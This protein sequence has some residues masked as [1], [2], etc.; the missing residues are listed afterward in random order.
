[1]TNKEI[2]EYIIKCLYDRDDWIKQVTDIEY[3]TRCPYCGDSANE[4]TGHFYIRI[5]PYDNYSI[6]YNCFKCQESGILTNETL[7]MLGIDDVNLKSSVLTMNKTSDKLD[8]KYLLEK[9]E[10]VTFD[11]ELPTPSRG[12]QTTYLEN[13]LGISLTDEDLKNLKVIT[14]VKDF[15]RFNGIDRITCEPWYLN[16]LEHHFLGFLSFGNSHILFRD[17]S[18]KEKIPWVKY[19]ITP[20]SRENRIF[21]SIATEMDPFT[22]D[23]ITI[24]LTEGIMDIISACYNLGYQKKNTLNIAVTGKHYRSMLLQLVSMGFVGSNITVNLFSDNDEK[25][26]RKQGYETTTIK[27]YRKHLHSYS[28]IFGSIN[29]FYNQIGKDIGVPKNKII[30]KKFKI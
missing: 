14:S 18:G 28:K 23:P 2:K 10:L 9:D 4:N 19:P 26:N 11:Y 6:V 24:N 16:K 20:K 12:E 29:I 15:L 27:Y 30:L 25:F 5:N 22:T 1:M 8:K 17:I 3:R 13:R 7:Q 21:Y